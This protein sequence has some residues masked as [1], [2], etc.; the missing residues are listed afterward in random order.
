MTRGFS[1]LNYALSNG[2]ANIGYAN[3]Q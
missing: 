1:G 2:F 3:A